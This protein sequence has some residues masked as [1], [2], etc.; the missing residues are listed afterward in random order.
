VHEV[1]NFCG[2]KCRV[3]NY[4]EAIQ[5]LENQ[6]LNSFLTILCIK[7]RNQDELLHFHISVNKRYLPVADQ[8]LFLN[9]FEKK[10]LE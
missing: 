10:P 9:I 2:S 8:K 7:S 5:V 4:T 1:K 6:N 3:I